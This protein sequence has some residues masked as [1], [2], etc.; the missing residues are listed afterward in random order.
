MPVQSK[1]QQA[2]LAIHHPDILHRWQKEAPVAL[3]KLPQRV[4]VVSNNPVRIRA[5]SSRK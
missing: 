3:S 2:F 1:A 4:K 5:L